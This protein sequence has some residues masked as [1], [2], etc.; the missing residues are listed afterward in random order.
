MITYTVYM[1]ENGY[2]GYTLAYD[3]IVFIRQTFAPGIGGYV[4]MTEAEAHAYAQAQVAE[5]MPP[6]A[7]TT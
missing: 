7:E 6:E 5:L 1:L 3:D 2:Y 4:P